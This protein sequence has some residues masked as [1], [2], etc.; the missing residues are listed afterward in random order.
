MIQHFFSNF[1]ILLANDKLTSTGCGEHSNVINVY[2][3]RIDKKLDLVLDHLNYTFNS[4]QHIPMDN[5]FLEN[6]PL[7]DID[8]IK[9]VEE[10]IKSEDYK[11]KIVR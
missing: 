8:S 2:L 5:T 1:C 7:K 6:F 11:T 4:V 3:N 9:K 10:N